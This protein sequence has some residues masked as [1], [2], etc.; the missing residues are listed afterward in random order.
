MQDTL[1]AGAGICDEQTVRFIAEHAKEC[2]QWLIDG[3]VPFD[4]EEDSDNDH[5]R[6]H[7]TREGGHSHRRILHAADATGM[8]MQTSLQD[9]AHN[10]PNITV[11]ERHNA[12]DLI[13]EDKIGG[14]ANKVVGAYVWNRNAEHVETIRANLW[15]WRLAGI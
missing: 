13:T 9:N 10:H 3:G 5:P 6:Y 15:C 1:I 14:D 4:K 2:V 8:A 12:L 7:L 11:L